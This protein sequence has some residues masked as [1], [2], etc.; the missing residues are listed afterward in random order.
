[1]K[2]TNRNSQP[3]DSQ[4]REEEKHYSDQQFQGKEDVAINI[5]PVAENIIIKATHSNSKSVEFDADSSGDYTNK[6]K[7]KPRKGSNKSTTPSTDLPLNPEE[8]KQSPSK[9]LDNDGFQ[10]VTKSPGKKKR[11]KK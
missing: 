9:P 6:L 4:D 8:S 11:S 5:E 1:M 7:K 3:P 10:T 2:T